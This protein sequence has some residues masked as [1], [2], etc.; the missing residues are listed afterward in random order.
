VGERMKKRWLLPF[1]LL[2]ACGAPGDAEP[3]GESTADLSTNGFVQES[4]ADPQSSPTSVA[5]KYSKAQV[6]GDLDVAA[7]CFFNATSIISSVTDTKG[8]TWAVAAPLFRYVGGPASCA[9]YY[10]PHIVAAAANGNTVTVKFSGSTLDPDVRIAEYAGFVAL[11]VSATASGTTSLAS[12]GSAVTSQAGDL[13]VAGDYLSNS[14]NGPGVGFTSRVI[15]SPDSDILEDEVTGAPGAYAAT[16]PTGGGWWVMQMAAF[17]PLVSSDAGAEGGSDAQSGDAGFADGA[18]VEAGSDAGT[19]DAAPDVADA[20]VEAGIDSAAD[21]LADGANDTG[22]S[23]VGGDASEDDGGAAS[24]D[25]TV[26]DSGVAA[27]V[28][29][30][31]VSG[32]NLRGNSLSS[33][34]CYT[35]QLPAPAQGGNAIVVGA[36][37]KG[38]ATLHVTDDEGDA[39]AVNESYLD[40]VD[41]QSVGIASTF[42]VAAGARAL[43]VCFSAN[44]GGWVQ[45]VA[46]ELANVVAVDG[47]AATSGSGT[48]ASVGLSA[49]SD[50]LYQVTYT[51]GG[52][53]SSFA[54]GSG[55]TLLSADVLDGFAD[56]LGADAMALGSSV[57]WATAAVAL[58]P[59]PSGAVPSG[60][61]IVRELHQNIPSG[62]QAGGSGAFPN[63]LA[64]QFPS[65]GNLLVAIIAGGCGCQESPEVTQISDSLSNTWLNPQTQHGGDAFSQLWYA[66]NATTSSSLRASASW[67]YTGADETAIVWDVAGASTSPLDVSA[68][69]SGSVGGGN[70]TLPFTI[71]TAGPGELIFVG[72]PWDFDTAG[73]LLGGASAYLA[74]MTTSG[75]PH[76][77]PFPIDENNGWGHLVSGT[78]PTSIT[79]VPL[80]GGEEFGNYSAVA[81][82]FRGAP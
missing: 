56:Q 37:W 66:P 45:P 40:S 14:T 19:V 43:S 79:W 22:T 1:F 25:A 31:H 10:A 36:T 16:A 55:G 53:P 15:T 41:G 46:T 29:V 47:A 78:S 74:T 61:R 35:L 62:S 49:G 65:S 27:A 33:P 17:K 80:F 70:L 32:S 26:Y 81:A 72:T 75:E 57:H 50:L 12:S 38:S 58:R 71:P 69:G 77:G 2:T 54:A 67:T 8:N 51:P 39:Y 64:L 9:M 23:E 30:Q 5:V 60:M 11:D 68:G 59:G 18:T 82:A 7:I 3:T 4:S 24:P 28:L 52:P 44:P 21:A 73:G 20:A 34:Y 76:D 48:S 63:P 6:A 13:I 42:G